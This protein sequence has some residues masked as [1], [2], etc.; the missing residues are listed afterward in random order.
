MGKNGEQIPGRLLVVD[1]D[2]QMCRLVGDVLTEEGHTVLTATNGAEALSRLVG[3]DGEPF[4]LMITDLHLPAMKGLD[5]M[6][7]ARQRQPDLS[8]II[9]TAFGSIESAIDAMK[10][11]AY[12]YLPKPFKIEELILT[13]SKALRESALRR[14]V[15]RLREELSRDYRFGNLIGKSKAI[16]SMFD[17]IRSVASATSNV[18]ITGESGTGKELVAKAIHYNG[19]R[20]ERPF[21]PVNCAAIPDTLMESELFGHVK[22]AFTDARSDKAG[23]F[24]EAEGGTLF[25]DEVTEL[26]LPLQAKLLRVL[27]EKE[28]RRVGST[29]QTPVDVRVIAASNVD[30]A[31]RVESREFRQDL[32]YRL[33]VIHIHVPPLRERRDDILLLA[34]RFLAARQQGNGATKIR[35]FS[36]QVLA[37]FLDYGWPGNVR[38]LENVVERAV[39]VAKGEL[40]SMEDLPS[41]MTGSR[42]DYAAVEHAARR[43]LSLAELERDYIARMIEQTGGNKNRAAQILGIDRK[44]LYR[45]LG[46]RFGHSQADPPG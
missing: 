16:R 6:F 11:G 28:I 39:V 19:V 42:V 22:G 5:L 27:Q 13:V 2:P 30:V 26:P 17:L 12:D 34:E 32:F 9:I 31:G 14:E 20:R 29:R 37:L 33:N 35:G 24:E 41:E 8:V 36:E 1:D 25:L 15:A 3:S 40:I 38:E 23:L 21:V 43:H 10:Q 4:D 18:L 44:T 7:Q 45:K 46:L